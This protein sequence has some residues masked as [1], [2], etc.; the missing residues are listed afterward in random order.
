MYPEFKYNTGSGG[1][2]AQGPDYSMLREVEGVIT[3]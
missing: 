3:K 2:K 1:G